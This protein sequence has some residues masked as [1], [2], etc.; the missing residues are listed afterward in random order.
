M[1]FHQLHN[2][3]WKLFG[4]KRTYIGFG[5]FL[6]AQN[7]ML[8]A[9]RFTNWRHTAEKM[10]AGNG[11][12]AQDYI[13]ALTVAVIM[14]I[15]QAVFLMPLYASLVGGDLVAKE[16]EDGTLRMILARPVSRLRLLTVKWLAGAVFSMTLVISLGGMALIFARLWFP[17]GSMFV[18]TPGP[19]QIFSVM[20]AGEGLWLFAMSH[21]CMAVNACTMLG[22]SF[23][24]SC[25]NMKPAAAT[26]LALSFLLLNL[27]MENI[28]F[29]EEYQHFFLT[30][31]FR[32]W[33]LVFSK[34]TPWP[35]M[36]Q[37]L[38]V[39]GAVNVT[40]FVI[41]AV[42]FHVRDIKS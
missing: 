41:G 37:S 5:T 28:P 4:K 16:A 32:S 20:P 10:L 42:G 40:A 17:W 22:L 7:A 36:I 13:T 2:E 9:F 11:Y 30:H 6:L 24:F 34:P 8:L 27:V 19:V 3:L 29:F 33:L 12:L 14:L 25:F 39:L 38:C 15:P 26:V 18:F 23:M 31:H 21:L 1:F 35:Q